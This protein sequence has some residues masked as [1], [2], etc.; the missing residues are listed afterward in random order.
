MKVRGQ[1]RVV[2]GEQSERRALSAARHSALTSHPHLAY[3][4][5][6]LTIFASE[7]HSTMVPR[8]F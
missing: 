4:M 1:W 8:A 7:S 5:Y 2:S 3:G 6:F